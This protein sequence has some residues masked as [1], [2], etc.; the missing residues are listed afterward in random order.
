MYR[1][2]MAGYLNKANDLLDDILAQD[3][4]GTFED[5]LQRAD[6]YAER[7]QND[8]D[9]WNYLS[10]VRNAYRAYMIVAAV[11][12]ELGIE[13]ST[14]APARLL[15]QTRMSGIKLIRSGDRITT[16][17]ALMPLCAR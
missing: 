2:E 1:W 16:R 13:T 15:G 17:L 9:S 7:A 3:D 11:A 5:R 8:F 4:A 12:A 14:A 10:A 6:R